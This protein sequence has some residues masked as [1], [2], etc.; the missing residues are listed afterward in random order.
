MI[1]DEGD[2]DQQKQ[3]ILD[4]YRKTNFDSPDA[5]DWQL[6]NKGVDALT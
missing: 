3:N 1:E 2:Q 5:I 6:L 4:I